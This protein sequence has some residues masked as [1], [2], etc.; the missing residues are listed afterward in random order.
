MPPLSVSG[1][2]ITKVRS[3]YESKYRIR[4]EASSR[5]PGVEE[6]KQMFHSLASA[7]TMESQ[8]IESC[9]MSFELLPLVRTGI[10]FIF[11][12]F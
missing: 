5:L 4:R 1:T 8:A 3:Q 7:T 9:A 10:F 11:L 6:N 12:V 2:G